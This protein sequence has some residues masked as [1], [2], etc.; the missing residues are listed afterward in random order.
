MVYAV[1]SNSQHSNCLLKMQMLFCSLPSSSLHFFASFF[2]RL[3]LSLSFSLLAAC[4]LVSKADWKEKELKKES[5]GNCDQ[6]LG[7]LGSREMEMQWVWVR[8]REENRTLLRPCHGLS[9]TK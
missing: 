9:I 7:M 2:L 8:E 1:D 5:N 4:R 6:Q 3:S